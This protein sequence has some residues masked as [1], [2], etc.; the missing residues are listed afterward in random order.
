MI[1]VLSMVACKKNEV[2]PPPAPDAFA[3]TSFIESQIATNTQHFTADASQSINI[4][5]NYGTQL[6]LGPNQLSD[7]NG[8][9]ISGNVDIELIEIFSK[10]GM[11]LLDKPTMALLPNGDHA[12]LVSD[13]EFYLNITQNGNEVT[14][15][16]PLNVKV[17]TGSIYDT[18]MKKFINVSPDDL[19]WEEAVDTLVIEEDSANGGIYYY[20]LDLL[21]GEWGWTNIDRFYNDPRPK[22][23]IFAELPEGFDNTN[24]QVYIS[25]DGESNALASFDTWVDGR[26]TEHYGLIPIGLEVH[27][28]AVAIVNDELNYVIEDVTITENHVQQISN[29]SPISDANLITL[30]DA[31]P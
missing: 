2:V 31:L 7:N 24:T 13:G 20:G 15:L 27:F 18:D 16:S 1:A 19:L 25:Y 26:F 11:V 30:I 10:S 8:T 22:T 5:G 12:T 6:S 17:P 4:E 28:V 3:L 14:L 23:T 29:F 9:V 21:P